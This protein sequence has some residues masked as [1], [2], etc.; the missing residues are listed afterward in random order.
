MALSLEFRVAQAAEVA[1]HF[2]ALQHLWRAA[3]ENERQL[4]GLG[5]LRF[6][7]EIMP[8][9]HRH[10]LWLGQWWDHLQHVEMLRQLYQFPEIAGRSGTAPAFKVGGVWCACARLENKGARFQQHI[11]VAAGRPALDGP[12]RAVQRSLDHL[13]ADPDHFG[14][15]IDPSA[16]LTKNVPCLGKQ[17]LHAKLLERA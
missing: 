6:H 5:Q 13:S 15:V 2:E 14:R 4:V 7:G 17:D 10:I 8:D 1:Q 12:R 9:I 16:P 3:T 11:T